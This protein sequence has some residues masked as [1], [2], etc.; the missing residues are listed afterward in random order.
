M[1]ALL[2]VALVALAGCGEF[3]DSFRNS[4]REKS[5]ESCTA[6]AR[7]QLAR[8]GAVLPDGMDAERICGCAV[9]RLMAGKSAA[10]LMRGE[11]EDRDQQR[12]VEE[13]ANQALGGAGGGKPAG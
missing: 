4:F 1:R 8:S 3:D 10:E 13:C 11:P 6:E 7:A 12:A 2:L 9:D 5:V